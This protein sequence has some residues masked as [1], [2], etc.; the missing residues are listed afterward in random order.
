MAT[1]LNH[2]WTD[3][4]DQMNC[5]NMLIS[6]N[7][8]YPKA[9]TNDL[10]VVVN[11]FNDSASLSVNISSYPTTSVFSSRLM[12][13]GSWDVAQDFSGVN[14]TEFAITASSDN[15]FVTKLTVYIETAAA[16]THPADYYGTIAPGTI[17]NGINIQYG[18]GG[19]IILN[20]ES[21][22][23]NGDWLSLTTNHLFLDNTVSNVAS[24]FTLKIVDINKDGIQLN[25]G[26]T[27]GVTVNDDFSTLAGHYFTVQGYVLSV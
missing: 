4:D 13:G 25:N 2:Y 23:S 9:H 17:T 15:T 21:I 14:G 18:S 19:S 12:S 5:G 6:S 27:F 16:T 26:D 11:G 8:T 7:N 24:I 10:P 1:Q 3:T 22:V 20:N